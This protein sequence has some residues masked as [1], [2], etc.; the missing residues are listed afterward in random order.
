MIRIRYEI[1]NSTIAGK[2]MFAREEIASG[3][4]IFAPTNIDEVI[5]QEEFAERIREQVHFPHAET[6]VVWFEDIYS[7]SHAWTDDCYINHSVTP[8]SIWH[9]GFVIAITDISAGSEITM[10]YR[11]LI[12]PHFHTEWH[13]KES[14]QPI[15][16]HNWTDNFLLST[17]TLLSIYHRQASP[18]A[19][20]SV[21]ELLQSIQDDGFDS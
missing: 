12:D 8:N 15:R 9:L 3:R 1:E 5:S 4:I 20:Q 16:G 2:G 13:D 7:M 19:R 11:H 17:A 6:S 10:D 14:G 21:R 18:Q